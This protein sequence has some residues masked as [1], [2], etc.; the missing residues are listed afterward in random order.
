MEAAKGMPNP[1]DLSGDVLS[2]YKLL[3]SPAT[4]TYHLYLIKRD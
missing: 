2:V 3:S 4:G 1:P